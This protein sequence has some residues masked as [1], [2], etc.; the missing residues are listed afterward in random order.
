MSS[1]EGLFSA[2]F[3]RA[4]VPRIISKRGQQLHFCNFNRSQSF[5]LAPVW[6]F[7]R[8][9]FFIWHQKTSLNGCNCLSTTGIP[10]CQPN[11][12]QTSSW[13]QLNGANERGECGGSS[14]NR[15]S[16][17]EAIASSIN[18]V[19]VVRWRLIS[20]NRW[21]IEKIELNY[22]SFIPLTGVLTELTGC[23]LKSLL[24]QWQQ[25]KSRYPVFKN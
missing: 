24:F 19:S 5:T 2:E 9:Q 7:S 21:L 20:L 25:N 1:E 17:C 8:L 12:R 18:D 16:V 6:K 23:N 4:T 3:I 10:L 13:C 22:L 14:K 11:H 15:I